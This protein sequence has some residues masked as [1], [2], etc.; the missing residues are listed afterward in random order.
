MAERID[1]NSPDLDP[2]QV[3]CYLGLGSRA[4]QNDYERRLLAEIKEIEAK[5]HLVEIP[6]N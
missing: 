6:F 2:D 5:G 1:P 3:L 4:P